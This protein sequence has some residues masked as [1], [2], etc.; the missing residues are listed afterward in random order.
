M[1]TAT[2]AASQGQSLSESSK[3]HFPT[4]PKLPGKFFEPRQNDPTGDYTPNPSK[5]FPL[6]PA[7]KALVDDII[8]LY[9]MGA[10]VERMQ[11]Y[12]PDAVY[13]DEVGYADDRFKIASQWFGLS[14][15]FREAKSHGHE[16][17][18]NDKD[19]IQF[20][21]EITWQPK[22]VP[23]TLTL[24]SLVSLSLD[25]A[26]VDGEFIRVK[27]HKDQATA[28]DY[29]NEGLG[30]MLKKWQVEATTAILSAVDSNLQAFVHDKGAGS[31]KPDA[32]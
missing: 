24:K 11:R 7:R 12:T 3:V 2:L 5:S 19:L 31:T 25:P 4:D 32:S 22:L 14:Y 27:Y 29:S 17:I 16:I 20:L 13:N 1:T 8:S 30:A 15:V 23:K 26:T 10:T 18:T 9:E 28:K 21:H 6:S